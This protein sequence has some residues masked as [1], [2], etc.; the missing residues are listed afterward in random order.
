M[1]RTHLCVS[2]ECSFIGSCPLVRFIPKCRVSLRRVRW[3]S[4]SATRG[5]GLSIRHSIEQIMSLMD[6][7]LTKNFPVC[8]CRLDGRRALNR[9]RLKTVRPSYGVWG[10]LSGTTRGSGTH[11]PT[12]GNIFAAHGLIDSYFVQE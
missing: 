2:I 9:R 4:T 8:S 6:M 3:Q 11:R 1:N 5:A 10:D 12:S 7:V